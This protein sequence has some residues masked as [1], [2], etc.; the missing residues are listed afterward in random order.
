MRI[1]IVSAEVAPFAKVGGLADVAGSLPKALNEIGHHAAVALPGYPLITKNHEWAIE[2]DVHRADVSVGDAKPEHVEYHRIHHEG[3]DF[4]LVDSPRFASAISSDTLYSLDRDAYLLFSESVLVLADR[5]KSDVIHANDWHTGFIPVLMRERHA[6]RF[7][8]VASVFSV[9][10]LAYQGEFGPETLEVAGLRPEL[11]NLHHVEAYGAVNFLKSGCV[12]ADEVNTV[13]PTYAREIMWPQYGCR[14]EGLMWHLYNSGRL[15]GILNGIDTTVW[16]P[17]TDRTLPSNYSSD[18]LSGKLTCKIKL[19]EE[20]EM[21]VVADKPVFGMVSRLS[22][23]KGF[24]LVLSAAP[25][26]VESGGCLIV[27][28]LGDE[29][30]ANQLRQLESA[31]PKQIR[32]VNRFD[33]DVANRIYAGSDFFLMPSAFEPCG[34]GQMIAMRYATLPIARRTGGLA[35]TVFEGVNGFVFQDSDAGQF[36]DACHR[37][38][39]C[40]LEEPRFEALRKTAATTDVS[41]AKS[42]HEYVAMYGDAL[43]TRRQMQVAV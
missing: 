23:Q 30:F 36:W 14:L 29:S 19:L 20:L 43:A 9:H 34:L 3:V 33:A 32:F 27:Q 24:D 6:R 28:G 11:F 37:A 42:A 25:K 18:D 22:W 38:M 5:L 8:H 2:R 12:Y 13:S 16:D 41:W 40:F 26:I 35:D 1:L 7:D 10:N 39:A 17:S 15:R 4:W 31:F 21:E